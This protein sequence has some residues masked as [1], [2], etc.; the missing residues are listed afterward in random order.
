MLSRTIGAPPKPVCLSVCLPPILHCRLHLAPNTIPPQ[1]PPPCFCHHPNP[2]PLPSLH[3]SP[4]PTHILNLPILQRPLIPPPPIGPNTHRGWRQRRPNAPHHV[5][6]EQNCEFKRDKWQPGPLR[7]PWGCSSPQAPTSPSP[8]LQRP[9]SDTPPSLPPPAV[10]SRT[11]YCPPFYVPPMFFRSLRLNSILPRPPPPKPR[12][13]HPFAPSP[14]PQNLKYPYIFPQ[15]PISSPLPRCR[16]R[17]GE[18]GEVL[19]GLLLTGGSRRG[20]DGVSSGGGRW[21][22]GGL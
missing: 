7:E 18:R 17:E 14:H 11:I 22:R 12:F 9:P 10:P 16:L 20:G 13:P 2:P 19:G 4:H 21:G 1:T 5:G 6:G 3:I 15:P 8:P